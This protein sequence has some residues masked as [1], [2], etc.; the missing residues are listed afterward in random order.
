MSVSIADIFEDYVE[1]LANLPSEIDQHMHELRSMDEHFQRYRDVYGKQKRKYLKLMRTT[2]NDENA[3]VSP[4]TPLPRPS[5]PSRR[6]LE[7]D[8]RA[9]LQKQDQKIELAMRMYDLISRH[10]ERIDNQM[11][12][13]Q[14]VPKEWMHSPQDPVT[15]HASPS[16]TSLRIHSSTHSNSSTSTLQSRRRPPL[17]PAWSREPSRRKTLM[18]G[19]Q[20]QSRKRVH[21]P[22]YCYCNQVSFGDMVACDGAN[23]EKE[24][25]HYSCVGL[26]E[27]PQGKWFCEDCAEQDELHRFTY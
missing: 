20:S 9:A 26:N 15:S 24:W 1:S 10:I 18:N 13:S 11:A 21:E 17:D 2:V 25:F 7:T 19:Q 14:L 6:Q 5:S 27:P 16:S 3:A 8:F 4:S 12:K 22:R 23:C